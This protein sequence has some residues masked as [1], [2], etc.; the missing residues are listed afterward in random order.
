MCVCVY[1]TE[2]GFGA[3][4]LTVEKEVCFFLTQ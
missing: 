2:F 4:A 1:E 3:A